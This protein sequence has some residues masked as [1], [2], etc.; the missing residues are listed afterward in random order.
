[1]DDDHIDYAHPDDLPRH[2]GDDVRET[3]ENILE[4]ENTYL[5]WDRETGKVSESL[6]DFIHKLKDNPEKLIIL[7][8]G[9]QRKSYLHVEETVKAILA[10]WKSSDTIFNIG[11]EDTIDVDGIADIVAE[12]MSLEPEYEYTGGEKGWDGD[13]P[14]M[15]LSIEKL[16]SEG[17]KP[18]RNS[19]ES[20]RKTV[21]ELLKN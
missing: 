10:S 3:L 18:S 11:S 6:C 21:R 5:G 7:G 1:M 8:N 14:E 4:H 2:L 13:V 16:K 15:R 17:W 20:V 12:E 19:S 9:K